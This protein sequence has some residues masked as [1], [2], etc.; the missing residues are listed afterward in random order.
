[1]D[2]E[3]K[4]SFGVLAVQLEKPTTTQLVEAAAAWATDPSKDLP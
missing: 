1:M 3:R 4:P 2:R